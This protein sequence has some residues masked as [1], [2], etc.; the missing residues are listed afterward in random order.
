MKTKVKPVEL[1][2]AELKNAYEE[3]KLESTKKD[4]LQNKLIVMNNGKD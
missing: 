2:A 4:K 1:T 3:Q